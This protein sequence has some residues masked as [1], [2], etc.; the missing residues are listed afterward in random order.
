MEGDE[1]K[2]EPGTLGVRSLPKL[3]DASL[4]NETMAASALGS[5]TA[6]VP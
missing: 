4:V 3:K 6:T 1:D 2:D 5:A